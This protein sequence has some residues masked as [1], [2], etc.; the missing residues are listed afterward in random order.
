VE[1]GD[2]DVGLLQAVVLGV[3][4]GVTEFL[5]I[6]STAHLRLV[7]ALLGWG[8]PGAAFSAVI[9]L[10]TVAAALFYFRRDL[11][12]LGTAF[13]LSLR[14]GKPFQSKDSTL[15]WLVLGGTIP[16]G[17]CGLVFK[18]A[19]ETQLRT[20]TV[21]AGALIVLA[22][23]LAV[24]E[25]WAQRSKDISALTLKDGVLIGLAQALALIPGAS[26]SGTTI[27][28]GL[29]LG[30]TREAAA[31][32]SFLLSI[33]ATSLAGLFELKRLY[34][35]P[36]GSL[37]VLALAT[38]VSFASGLLAIGALLKFLKTRSLMPFVIYRV[39][40]GLGLLVLVQRGL[41]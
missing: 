39:L 2:A 6:S 33:P 5:P 40:L 15:A 4:Q 21:I 13:F 19:I 16:I 3:V 31:R 11:S 17:L 12:T 8:D 34:Q 26:R 27:T 41:V 7:P 36:H 28:A 10:G 38:M 1:S 29:A 35:S 14:Q 30:F 18:K 23:V 24:V 32:Y 22:I 25:R 9:Q 20:L 37:A